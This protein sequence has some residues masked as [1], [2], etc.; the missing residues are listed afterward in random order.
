MISVNPS[1]VVQGLIIFPVFS[2]LD[3]LLWLKGK[4]FWIVT[5]QQGQYKNLKCLC[6]VQ[7]SIR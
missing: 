5:N 4:K 2:A 6:G 3:W 7:M 1:G